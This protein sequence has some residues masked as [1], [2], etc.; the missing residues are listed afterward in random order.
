MNRVPPIRRPAARCLPALLLLLA[1]LTACRSGT[2]TP[3]TGPGTP[4]APSSRPPAATITPVPINTPMPATPVVTKT[5]VQVIQPFTESGLAT[6]YTRTESLIGS[7]IGPSLA[8][9]GRSD[10]WRCNIEATGELRDPC[11][12]QGTSRQPALVCFRQ[13]WSSGVAVYVLTGPL[14]E[15]KPSAGD[16]TAAHP[17]GM[18]L[19]DGTR[20]LVVTGT[21]VTVAGQRITSTCNGSYNAIGEVDRSQPVWTI[22][23]VRGQSTQPERKA[24]VKAWY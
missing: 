8:S 13:P 6:G 19:A 22:Q 12:A 4:A 2:A 23:V 20:C 10:A 14:P 5:E 18:E 16:P 17:W 21:P 15:A 1:L 9:P 7:C 11:F 24:I 3:T